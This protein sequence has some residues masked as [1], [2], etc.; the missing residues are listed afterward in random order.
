MIAATGRFTVVCVTFDE[1]QR[2]MKAVAIPDEWREKIGVAPE[3]SI[4]SKN[5]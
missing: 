4:P 1:E 5:A 2:R 3:G